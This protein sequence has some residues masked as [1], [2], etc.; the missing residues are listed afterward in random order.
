MLSKVERK[1]L[2]AL[3][4]NSRTQTSEL[5]KQVGTSRQVVDYHI[6]QLQ[7]KDILLGCTALI[8]PFQFVENIWHTY[9]KLQSLTP[10]AE[11]DLL[12]YLEKNKNVWWIARCQGEW[13]LIFSTSGSRVIELDNLLDKFRTKFSL[14]IAAEQTTTM[15]Q[16][17][18]FP[19]GYLTNTKTNKQSYMQQT[20]RQ[21]IDEK[22]KAILE[23]LEKNARLPATQIAQETK[24]TAR[25]VIYRIKEL[26][27]KGVI[28]SFNTH[29]N[30]EKLNYDYY[31]VCIYA[32]KHTAQLA[33]KL[34]SW[35]EQN[36]HA[37][38]F[39]KKI[40]PWTFEIEFETPSYKE[41]NLALSDLR[42]TFGEEIRKTETTIITK[43][44]KGALSI[45]H[46]IRKE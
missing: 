42:N 10:Q 44:Y 8:D 13:D 4:K 46:S 29:I 43:E 23:V 37:L 45:L 18:R 28:R 9:I 35:C 2:V 21:P 38:Y 39:V 5:A 17:Q 30:L 40:A 3:D 25:Q 16:A 26:I 1:L 12:H 27:K 7:Q 34:V 32:N 36:P 33:H 31:K 24:L 15:I 19:R 22:D 14:Y 41:L 20:Q 6:E 11:K